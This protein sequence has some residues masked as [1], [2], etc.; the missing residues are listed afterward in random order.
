[1]I[2]PVA[3]LV[4]V[5]L[6][7]WL[8]VAG[9]ALLAGHADYVLPT[10]VAAVICLVPA[11]A[12]LVWALRSRPETTAAHMQQTLLGSMAR[13]GLTAAGGLIA[14]LGGYQ[15]SVFLV[16]LAGFYIV[17]LMVETRLLVADR[18]RRADNAGH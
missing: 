10:M 5:M 7:A 8:C 9:G 11:L 1:M 6:G 18:S 14:Y 3:I 16:A 13:I 12:T 15:S 17:V 4:S 2:R